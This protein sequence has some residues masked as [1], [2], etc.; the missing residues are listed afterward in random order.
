M[1]NKGLMDLISPLQIER[2]NKEILSRFRDLSLRPYEQELRHF[3]IESLRRFIHRITGSSIQ[4]FGSMETE[5]GLPQAD[6]DI[7]IQDDRYPSDVLIPIEEA[8][9]QC[10]FIKSHE[11][12]LTARV[13]VIK[14]RSRVGDIPIDISVNNFDGIRSSR[15]VKEWCLLYPPLKPLALILK[16]YLIQHNVSEVY[17]GGLGG[18]ALLNMLVSLFQQYP[19]HLTH[20]HAPAWYFFRFFETY[21]LLFQYHRQGIH[22]KLGRYIPKPKEIVRL[23]YHSQWF[24]QEGLRLYILDPTNPC[25]NVSRGT[26]RMGEIKALFLRSYFVLEDG[27]KEPEVRKDLLREVIRENDGLER[28]RRS[29][30]RDWKEFCEKGSKRERSRERSRSRRRRKTCRSS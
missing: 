25:N 19:G 20:P 7:S 3:L 1:T 2:L 16:Q 9:T 8:L 12:I 21:G 4:I 11:L 5:L 18:Y 14:C 23:N 10:S 15:L 28:W 6:I 17:T 27:L 30:E 26:F 22:V 29:V 13:P 24:G